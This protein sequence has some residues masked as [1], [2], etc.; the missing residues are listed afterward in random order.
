MNKYLKIDLS[1]F[2]DVSIVKTEK[3]NLLHSP[4]GKVVGKTNKITFKDGS[5]RYF[6]D[7][8]LS[9]GQLKDF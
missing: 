1:D 6:T 5:V 2:E 3:A 4:T 8:E 7:E 9:T